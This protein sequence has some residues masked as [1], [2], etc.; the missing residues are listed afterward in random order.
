MV[1]QKT[2]QKEKDILDAAVV[3]FSTV[4]FH[5]TRIEQI[6]AQAGVAAGTIYLYFRNKEEILKAIFRRFAENYDRQIRHGFSGIKDPRKKLDYLIS[7]DFAVITEAPERSRL[8]LV[9]LRQSQTSLL[10]IKEYL[11]RRYQSYL[12][13]VCSQDFSLPEETIRFLAVMVSGILENLLFE[14]VFGKRSIAPEQFKP[15]ILNLVF[16]YKPKTQ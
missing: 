6:A 7:S 8:F 14:H 2:G 16:Y 3:L 9:E 4:G 13:E 1:R 5:H 15:L 10:F 11:T 12:T